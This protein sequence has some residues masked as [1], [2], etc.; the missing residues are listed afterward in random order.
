L[1]AAATFDATDLA[2]GLY[3]YRVRV[4]ARFGAV[5]D[6]FTPSDGDFGVFVRRSPLR[7]RIHDKPHRLG[8]EDV[9]V[10]PAVQFREQRGR[11]V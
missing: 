2:A 8:V 7:F 11:G 6:T 9:D 10:P 5:P 1:R 3:P 4:T